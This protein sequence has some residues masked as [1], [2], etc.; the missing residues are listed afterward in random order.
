MG[1]KRPEKEKEG[2]KNVVH[3]VMC[4]KQVLRTTLED[5]RTDEAKFYLF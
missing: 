4:D 2:K 3:L 5:T 1:P